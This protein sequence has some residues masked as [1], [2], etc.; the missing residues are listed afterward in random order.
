MDQLLRE[1]HS[2]KRVTMF[3]LPLLAAAIIFA[4][5]NRYITLVLLAVT[6]LYHVFYSRKKQKNYSSHVTRENLLA[7]TC[8]QLGTRDI[9]EN[10]GGAITEDMILSSGL[11]PVKRQKGSPLL[12]YGISGTLNG[13][14]ICLC[15]ATVAQNF[16]L[17]KNGR[18]RVHFNS[19]VWVRIQ[20]PTNPQLRYC[21]YEE[22]SVPTPIRMEF[23]KNKLKMTK[24]EIEEPK[25]QGRCVLYQPSDAGY[26]VSTRVEY[27]FAKLLD[28]TPGYPAMSV[29]NDHV[30]FFL[31]G[32]FVARPVSVSN[33]P[34]QQLIDFDPLPELPY[35]INIAREIK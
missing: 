1:Y 13:W 30:D 26:Q 5:I 21:L 9:S 3:I 8:K 2:M 7:T 35:L 16:T 15:D 19:G 25:L 22:S 32:R 29:K 18:K 28:Y 14:K 23:Y 11:M 24:R 4:F 12:C 17:V 34:T 27:E 20:L 10:S 33:A 6:L 31:R